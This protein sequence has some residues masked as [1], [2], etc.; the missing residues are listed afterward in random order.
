VFTVTKLREQGYVIGQSDSSRYI[1]VN[2]IITVEVVNLHYLSP[3]GITKFT[4]ARDLQ[5]I[6]DQMCITRDSDNAAA[7]L[8]QQDKRYAAHMLQNEYKDAV[9]QSVHFI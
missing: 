9:N 2:M 5:D 1:A 3:A 7:I 4:S 6:I 8:K